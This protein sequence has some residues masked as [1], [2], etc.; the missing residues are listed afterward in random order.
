LPRAVTLVLSGRATGR[1]WAKRAVGRY[2]A[3]RVFEK[4]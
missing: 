2:W 4:L 3:K 1:D